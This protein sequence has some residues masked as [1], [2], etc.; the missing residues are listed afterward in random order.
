MKINKFGVVYYSVDDVQELIY[1]NPDFSLDGILI[2][3][4]AD[5]RAFDSA[6]KLLHTKYKPVAKYFDPGDISIE[7]FDSK[8]QTEWLMPDEYKNLDIAQWILDQCSTDAER[9]RVGQELLLYQ[10]RDMFNVLRFLKYFVDTMRAKNLV[11]GVG[12]GSSTASYCLFLIGVHR[13]DSMFFNLPIEE[14]LK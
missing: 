9:Q 6:N 8:N 4:Y 14:F 12:R 7:E 3:N 1:E 13:I 5:A 11:W 2:E 10:D